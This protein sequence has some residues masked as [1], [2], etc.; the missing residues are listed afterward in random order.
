MINATS[1]LITST[2]NMT[3]ISD[4]CHCH[5]HYH[6]LHYFYLYCLRSSSGRFGHVF[7]A[8][9]WWKISLVIVSPKTI[10]QCHFPDFQETLYFVSAL[11]IQTFSFYFTICS[12]FRIYFESDLFSLLKGLHSSTGR[13]NKSIDLQKTLGFSLKIPVYPEKSQSQANCYDL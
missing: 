6:H 4:I 3:S 1:T 12:T 13:E 5:H 10:Y 8:T 2:S 9:V 7:S 11:T